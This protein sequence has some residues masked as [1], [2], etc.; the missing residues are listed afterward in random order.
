[1][2]F[3]DEKQLFKVLIQGEKNKYTIFVYAYSI[4]D[5]VEK[6]RKILRNKNDIVLVAKEIL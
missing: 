5:A 2:N 4:A 1:M 6:S 3:D